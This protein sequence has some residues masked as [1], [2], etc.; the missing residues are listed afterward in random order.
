MKAS[1]LNKIYL[2][3]NSTII[4]IIL[5]KISNLKGITNEKYLSAH[6]YVYFQGLK[7]V[8]GLGL[9]LVLLWAQ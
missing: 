3:V 9:S 1:I 4:V 7:L 8:L 6:F 2:G 5:P